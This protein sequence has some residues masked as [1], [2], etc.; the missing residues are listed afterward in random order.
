M[1][2]TKLTQLNESTD[3]DLLSKLDNVCK[4]SIQM[5][6]KPIKFAKNTSNEDKAEATKLAIDHYKSRLDNFWF[7]SRALTSG[8]NGIKAYMEEC[9]KHGF[10]YDAAACE[11]LIGEMTHA[12]LVGDLASTITT[13]IALAAQGRTNRTWDSDQQTAAILLMKVVGIK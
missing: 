2:L 13:H 11:K 9:S 10:K 4:L 12:K 3:A 6:L 5:E 7:D 1:N 8:V